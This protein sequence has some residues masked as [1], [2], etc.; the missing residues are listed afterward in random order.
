[1]IINGR[2]LGIF[3]MAISCALADAQDECSFVNK[4]L[5]KDDSFDCCSLGY[6]K[7]KCSKDHITYIDLHSNNIK[8]EFPNSFG[9][10]TKLVIL[11]LSDNEISGSLPSDIKNLKSLF[12][13]N[14]SSNQISGVIPESIS[15]LQSLKTLNLSNNNISSFTK[16]ITKIPLLTDLDLSGNEI[17]GG[18]IEEVKNFENLRVLNLGSNKLSGSIPDALGEIKNL[19]TL[20]LS[21]NNLDG[22]IPE[23][24]GKLTKLKYLL[25]NGNKLSGDIPTSS[26]KILTMTGVDLSDNILLSGK[27]PDFSYTTIDH[28]CV[29]TNTNLCYTKKE[30]D[31]KC[32]YTNYECSTCSENAKVD[33]NGVCV[34]NRNYSGLGYITCTSSVDDNDLNDEDNAANFRTSL[35]S[36]TIATMIFIVSY[37]LYLM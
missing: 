30:K 17:E 28:E 14:L 19:V 35:Q 11:N 12:E 23:A 31:S 9:Q 7:I 13:L 24:I 2:R 4:L 18:I 32:K 3:L 8:T 1:M 36:L 16:E 27:I 10:L 26:L 20:N 22:E 33:S 34:C 37:I 6:P 25:L 15:E 21:K 5:G 29:Y